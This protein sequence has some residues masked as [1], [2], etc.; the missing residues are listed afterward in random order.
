MDCAR[1]AF[2][3]AAIAYFQMERSVAGWRFAG[4]DTFPAAV[5][6]GFVNGIF[7]IVIVGIL[8]VDFAYDAPL[9]GIL[10]TGLSRRQP[11][12]VGLARDVEVR[13]AELAVTA[14][15][16]L[17]DRFNRRLAQDAGSPAQIAGNAAGGIDLEYAA[18]C[19]SARKQRRRS[20]DTDQTDN[21]EG[22]VHK[23]AATGFFTHSFLLTPGPST[24]K[25]FAVRL[26]GSATRIR[27]FESTARWR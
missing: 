7:V 26:T 8:L 16:K 1:V 9:K 22:A 5:A 2:E 3:A 20:P 12:F 15:G 24:E 19:R 25:T 11:L 10:G 14:L 23:L 6:K 13:G 18:F 17:V 21:A 4:F 27:P